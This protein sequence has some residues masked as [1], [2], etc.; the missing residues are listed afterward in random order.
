MRALLLAAGA[1][2]RLSGCKAL[3]ELGQSSALERCLAALHGGGAALVRVVLGHQARAV[4]ERHDLSRCE[5]VIN[6]AP[7][8]GQTSSLLAGLH[9]P[10]AIDGSRIDACL[11]HTVDHPLVRAE[12]VAALLAA[13]EQRAPGIEVVVPS[14]GGRRGHPVVF[15]GR[16]LRELAGLGVDEP[17]H[18]VLR[19]DP[20][21]V[22][23]VLLQDPWLV[24][25]LDDPDDLA[26]ARGELAR[27][28]G[29]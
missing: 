29:R 23:H 21:R 10:P 7:D 16:A 14:V 2:R 13:W 28:E 11:L 3:L 9:A 12:E 5:V 18:Q 25:D 24:R 22:Q 17:A 15:G 27:R 6:S 20:G 26:A 8:R 4:R 1:G 19:R